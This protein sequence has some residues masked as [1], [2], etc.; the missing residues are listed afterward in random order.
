MPR[1]RLLEA[2]RPEERAKQRQKLGT[3][4]DLTVQPATKQRYTKATDA[5]LLFLQKEGQV[6]PREKHRMDP[7]LCD[8][9]EHLWSSGAGRAQACDTLAGLQDIQPNLRNHLPGAWRLLRTWHVNE[10]PNRAPPLPEH[11]LQSMAGWAFFKG[12]VSF[13]VSLVL[14]YYTMLRTG[15]LVGVRSSHMISTG[16]QKQ[17]LVSLGL[18]KGGKRHGAAESVILG[19]EPAVKLVKQWKLKATAV[20]PLAKNPAHWRGLFHDCL[21]DLGLEKHGFRPYS[22][23]RGGA[24]F[25]FGKHQSLDK[26]LVQGRWHTQKSARIYLNEGLSVLATMK[27]PVSSPNIRP[28]YDVF[29]RTVQNPR[30]GTLEPPQSGRSGGRGKRA[31]RSVKQAQKTRFFHVCMG[32]SF[33]F[34]T[35]YCCILDA[36]GCQEVWLGDPLGRM[37]LHFPYLG[38]G[39]VRGGG[40]PEDGT[41]VFS[42]YRVCNYISVRNLL[43]SGTKVSALHL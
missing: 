34:K 1:K 23:R 15:E 17:V 21:C 38:F 11:V 4:R 9:L 40:F 25:W 14:G 12:H 8:Y 28:Y 29:H 41:V 36:G 16:A 18:T 33:S 43:R 5:F 3:L 27:I 24:T 42:V 39:P 22:L 6:L 37:D 31:K 35:V 30:F 7:L 13:G 20:T 10:I 32:G 26:I 19:Y 2:A